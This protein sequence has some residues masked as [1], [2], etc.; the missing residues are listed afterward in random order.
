MYEF[1][2]RI[3]YSETDEKGCLRVPALVNY[4]QDC[5]TF[6]TCDSGKLNDLLQERN[7]AW[8]LSSWDIRVD[9]MP[10]VYEK[11][12]V[13]TSP[14]ERRGLFCFRNFWIR[15]KDSRD[16]LVR[17]DS[18]WFLYDAST[19]RPVRPPEDLFRPYGTPENVLGFPAKPVRFLLPE[20]MERL[21]RIPVRP[22]HL[23]SN[24]HVNNVSYIL[25]AED[26][27][28]ASFPARGEESDNTLEGLTGEAEASITA[29]G[30]ESDNAL[31]GLT[32]EVEASIPARGEGRDDTLEGLT[33]KV[34][35]SIPARGE[36]SDETGD[37]EVCSRAPLSYRSESCSRIRAEY[38]KAAKIG[39]ILHPYLHAEKNSDASSFLISFQSAR[40]EIFCNIEL[41]YR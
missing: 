34:E 29:R 11:L 9:R 13:G 23:D 15:E 7:L 2:I 24:H 4:L 30:E 3:R 40:N 33:E 6:H 26:A 16:F 27:L 22:S 38:K 31:E 5:S 28:R 18:T 35:A 25:L 1:D 20:N 12:V 32:G 37:P 19:G 41:S 17:A 8:L 14:H 39:D 21:E 36:R 10:R